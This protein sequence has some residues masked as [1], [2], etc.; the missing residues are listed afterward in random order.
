LKLSYMSV[1]VPGCVTNTVIDTIL[2]DFPDKE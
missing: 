2:V 1:L